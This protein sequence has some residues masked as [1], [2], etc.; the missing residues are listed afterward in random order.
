M[1]LFYCRKTLTNY[2]AGQ[3]LGFLTLVYPNVKFYIH[4]GT[5]TL[6]QFYTLNGISLDKICDMRVRYHCGWPIEVPL[7]YYSCFEHIT[8]YS[9][10]TLTLQVTCLP[11]PGI[12]KLYLGPPL[13]IGP[14]SSRKNT[15]ESHQNDS[16]S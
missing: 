8:T 15:K 4:I 13:F 2:S 5:S 12:W 11:Y 7:P 16:I 6:P 1:I 10:T 3:T 9:Y 14:T